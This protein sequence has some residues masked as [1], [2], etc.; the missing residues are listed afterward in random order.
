MTDAPPPAPRPDFFRYVQPG[1]HG[2]WRVL[3][4]IVASVAIAAVGLFVLAASY[5]S[6]APK[7]LDAIAARTPLAGPGRLYQEV[8][9]F[10]CDAIG[11][12]VVTL[13]ILAAA[14]FAFGRPA[15][16]FVAP[17]RRL[18][19]GL[20]VEGMSSAVLII[21]ATEGAS[22][23]LEG[24]THW[25]I[26][27]PAYSWVERAVYV[28]GAAPCLLL[29]AVVEEIAFRGV[30]LQVTS[31]LT[32]RR[33]ALSIL[34]GAIFALCHGDP[35]PSGFLGRAILGAIWSW[36]VLELGGLE[37]AIG[38]HFAYDW[39]AVMVSAPPSSGLGQK[40]DM[41]IN[42]LDWAA[43]SIPLL[44]AVPMVWLSARIRARRL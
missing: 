8:L 43:L 2:L 25:L 39:L 17:L 15:W 1:E 40:L 23:A 28:L 29:I 32:R 21:A 38:A 13:S 36:S 22:W 41:S 14:R 4:W 7:Y 26:A 30:L 10:N 35:T 3:G 27:D 11:I 33:L 24:S 34:N 19:P 12:T 20:L 6:F 37:F 16:T 42:M 5:A 9:S 44:I 18:A 31:G